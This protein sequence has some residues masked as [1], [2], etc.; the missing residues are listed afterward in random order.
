MKQLDWAIMIQEMLEH[1]S[2]ENVSRKTG[3]SKGYLSKVSKD[4]IRPESWDTPILILDAYLSICGR[5]PPRL[6][7][8]N[9]Y[10]KEDVA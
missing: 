2:I 7:E 10:I 9:V 8:H 4:F 1:T 3:V 5:N 6:G